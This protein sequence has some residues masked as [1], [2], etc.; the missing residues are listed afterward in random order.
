MDENIVL[1]KVLHFHS[2]NNWKEILRINEKSNDKNALKL[3]WVWPSEENLKFLESALA[4]RNIQGVTSLGCGCGLLE[5]IIQAYTGLPIVGFEINKEW[6]ESK[7]SVPA[8]IPLKYVEEEIVVETNPNFALLFCYFNNGEAF[9]EY[10]DNYRGNMVI[11]IGPHDG[12]GRH[13][14][15]RP[16]FPNFGQSKWHLVNYEEIKDTRDFI[17]IYIRS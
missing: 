15:P 4:E 14:D 1:E 16:F 10:V 13:T 6:W 5:W 3:L 2:N 9:R 12:S 11:I 7:Y 17:T 8:F